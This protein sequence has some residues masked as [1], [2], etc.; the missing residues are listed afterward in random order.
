MIFAKLDKTSNSQFLECLENIVPIKG[1]SYLG[2]STLYSELSFETQNKVLAGLSE[3]DISL[4]FIDISGFFSSF[5]QVYF[6]RL[7][8]LQICLSAF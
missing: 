3:Y 8:I 7:K 5:F 2:H 6:F 1:R 4:N